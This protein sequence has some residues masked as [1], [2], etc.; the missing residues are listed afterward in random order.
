[1]RVDRV[2]QKLDV[3][4]LEK[5]RQGHVPRWLTEMDK[6]EFQ[7]CLV[8]GKANSK[9]KLKQQYRQLLRRGKKALPAG[10]P[11]Q[12]TLKARAAPEH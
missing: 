1:M 7:I 11:P 2:G 12:H 4:G 8:A 5:F 10:M 3:F 6:L 9:S